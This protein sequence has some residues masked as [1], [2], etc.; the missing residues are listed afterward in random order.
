MINIDL[1]VT[2]GN[3]ETKLSDFGLLV[4]DIESSSP[5]LSVERRLVKNRSG[6]IIAGSQFTDKTIRVT[7]SFY[8]SNLLHYENIV[9]NVNGLLVNL[10]PFYITKMIPSDSELYG[11]ELPGQSTSDLNLFDVQHERYKYRYKV[12]A[13]GSLDFLFIGKSDKGLLFKFTFYF[14]TAEMPFGESIPKTL[15]VNGSYVPYEGSAHNSQLEYPW[16]VR[17]VADRQQS[18]TFTIQIGN[19]TFSHTSQTPIQSGDVFLIKGIETT[20]NGTNVNNFTNRE[21]FILEPQ[22]NGRI[23]FDTSFEGTVEINNFVEFYK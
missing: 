4:Q 22:A 11:F 23:P 9:E 13:D 8:A 1:L 15:A 2:K 18:G 19:R 7:G 17:L 16:T 10:E 6:T 20:K 5:N 14:I 21:H 3:E 12:F